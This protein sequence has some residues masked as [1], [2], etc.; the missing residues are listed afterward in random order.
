[1]TLDKDKI[2]SYNLLENVAYDF[3][4]LPDT[5]FKSELFYFG[6]LAI[7]SEKSRDTLKKILSKGAD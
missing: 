4:S 5:V 3:I 1:M 2:P 7:R 6:T